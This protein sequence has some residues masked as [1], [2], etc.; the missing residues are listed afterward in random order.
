MR[1]YLTTLHWI[2]LLT[3][4]SDAAPFDFYQTFL[5]TI[6]L[7]M[8]TI[9]NAHI[10]GELAL[11]FQS[12]DKSTKEFQST[13]ALMNTAMINLN[14]PFEIQQNVRHELFQGAPSQLSQNQLK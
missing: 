9:I 1:Q 2:V 6:A 11:I 13:L 3:L 12:L 8:G 5:A 14:L 10:F 4:G 7:F